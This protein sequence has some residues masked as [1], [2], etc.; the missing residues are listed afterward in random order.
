MP[1]SF[2]SSW[3]SKP[4]INFWPPAPEI[5]QAFARRHI[6]LVVQH[7]ACMWKSSRVSIESPTVPGAGVYVHGINWSSELASFN[8]GRLPQVGGTTT[9][10]LWGLLFWGAYIRWRDVEYL[11]RYLFLSGVV[12]CCVGFIFVCSNCIS[13]SWWVSMSEPWVKYGETR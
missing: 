1:L 7:A 12:C 2:S 5:Q 11:S 4:S 6:F 10:K 8:A 9:G 13:G 3:T